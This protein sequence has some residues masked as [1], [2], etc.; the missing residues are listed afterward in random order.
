MNELTSLVDEMI[1]DLRRRSFD[2]LNA[3]PVH[4]DDHSKGYSFATWKDT[5]TPDVIRIVV[6]GYKSGLFGVGKMYA[7]GFRKTKSGQIYEL[8]EDELF[9]FS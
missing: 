7:Q 4:K 8:G 2:D 6:Q 9:E 3:L 5:L 1:S